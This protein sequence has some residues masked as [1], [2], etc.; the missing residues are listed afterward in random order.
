MGKRKQGPIQRKEVE[1]KADDA[2]KKER[3]RGSG[4]LPE[5]KIN[6]TSKN[7]EILGSNNI[8]KTNIQRTYNIGD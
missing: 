3:K 6:P 4:S 5:Q 7:Y 2:E 1:G 8:Q